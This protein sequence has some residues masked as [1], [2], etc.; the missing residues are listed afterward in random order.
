MPLEISNN[1]GKELKIVCSNWTHPVYEITPRVPQG[2]H[3]KTTI[4]LAYLQMS[5]F[6][7]YDACEHTKFKSTTDVGSE[8]IQE[9]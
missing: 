5:G 7:H 1:L 9:N 2:E 4:S 6:E 8:V 3:K